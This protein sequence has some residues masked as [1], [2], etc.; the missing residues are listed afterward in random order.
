MGEL[1]EGKV[2]EAGWSGEAEPGDFTAADTQRVSGA[3]GEAGELWEGGGRVMSGELDRVINGD[4]QGGP[5]A[6][7]NARI[8]R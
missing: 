5:L 2:R 7:L 8:N 3:S 1:P 4:R 6:G